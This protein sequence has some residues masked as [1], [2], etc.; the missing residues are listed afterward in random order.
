MLYNVWAIM[1]A[2]KGGFMEGMD[3][4]FEFDFYLLQITKSIM[5]AG[6]YEL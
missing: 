5:E 3:S 4:E 6:C 2:R 1:Q